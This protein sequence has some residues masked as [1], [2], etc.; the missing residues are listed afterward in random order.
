MPCE[1]FLLIRR[2]RRPCLLAIDDGLSL[3]GQH[4]GR[5][6]DT[7]TFHDEPCGRVDAAQLVG[8]L[9]A[10]RPLV[11]QL[12]VSYHES[13]LVAAYHRRVLARV[14]QL[15]AV[16]EAAHPGGRLTDVDAALEHRLARRRRRH[17]AERLQQLRTTA[18]CR[19]SYD[20]EIYT[21]NA[22]RKP[23]VWP[24]R[25]TVSRPLANVVKLNPV[26]PDA[27]CTYSGLVEQ[28][29]TDGQMLKQS[30]VGLVESES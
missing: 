18:A 1:Y 26:P 22:S 10:V 6:S 13:Y 12:R 27:C 30:R 21:R 15:A 23:R 19:P 3:A 20:T 9:A 16:A 11:G 25:P 28:S 8:G 5:G 17:V 24:A 29:Y 4:A 14:D 2:Q 7:R